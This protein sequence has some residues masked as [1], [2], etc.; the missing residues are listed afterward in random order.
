MVALALGSDK[1]LS[2]SGGVQGTWY[3]VGTWRMPTYFSASLSDV[4]RSA[5]TIQAVE[6]VFIGWGRHAPPYTV[7][8]YAGFHFL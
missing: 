4:H 3:K 6:F 1:W 7:S 5:S 2:A 8:P